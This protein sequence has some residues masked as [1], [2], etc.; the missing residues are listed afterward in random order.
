M[1]TLQDYYMGREVIYSK[2][3]TEG[4]VQRA[5][6]LLPKI[7]AILKAFGEERKVN[8]GWRPKQLQMKI[9]PKA[10]NSKH[11]TGDAID[12]ED[13]DGKFKLWCVA[14]EDVLESL[15]LHMEHPKATPT[16]VH[17]QQVAPKSGKVIFIP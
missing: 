13:R 14:H 7:D 10:P 1:I 6:L 5:T 11:I 15:G 2:D 8:S 12:L 9:N 17:L 3:L 4:V 16:W